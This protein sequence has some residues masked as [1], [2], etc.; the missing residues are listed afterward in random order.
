MFIA[1]AIVHLNAKSLDISEDNKPVIIYY[2]AEYEFGF[3]ENPFC[4]IAGHVSAFST[5]FFW[6]VCLFVFYFMSH[7]WE[8]INILCCYFFWW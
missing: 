5:F 1:T 4:S 6:F 7:K 8:M 3:G 2:A